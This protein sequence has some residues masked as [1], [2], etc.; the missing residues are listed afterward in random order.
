MSK[1]KNKRGICMADGGITQESPEQLMARMA[2]KY[3][4]PTGATP[5]AQPQQQS[6]QQAPQP[7][8]SNPLGIMSMLK[9]RSAQIDKAVNG[10][11]A[12]GLIQNTAEHWANDNAE[13][14]KTNPNFGQR[15]LRGLNPLTGFGSAMGAMH[16]AAGNG[17]VPGMAMAGI[18]AI[19]AFGVLRSVPAAG[20]MKAAVSPSLGRSAAALTGGAVVNAIADEYQSRSGQ[21][22]ANGGIVNGKGTPTSDDVPVKIKGKQY[23]LSDTEAV[24]PSKSR[25]ALGE[26]LG[27][28]PGNVAQA[29][30]L[31][32]KFIE[33]TNGKPPVSV[34]EGTNLADGGL[35]DE[36]ARK[37][38]YQ[39][40]TGTP[41]PAPIPAPTAAPAQPTDGISLGKSPAP[42]IYGNG[43]LPPDVVERGINTMRGQLAKPQ[44]PA[45]AAMG[46]AAVQA[47][48]VDDGAGGV[49]TPGGGAIPPDKAGSG[50]LNGI[51]GFFEDSARAARGEK[52]YEQLRA[53]RSAG[54]VTPPTA[55]PAASMNDGRVAVKADPFGP[56]PEQFSTPA[57]SDGTFM[58]GKAKYDETGL[59]QTG[60]STPD[61]SGGGFVQKNVSYN[62]NPT[63]QEG[64]TKITSSKTNPLFTNI[65]PE[66]AVASLKNQ[67]VGAHVACQEGEP[68]QLTVQLLAVASQHFS[69]PA[70]ISSIDGLRVDWPDGFG[71]IRA[72]NTTPVLVLRFEGHTQ[73]AL[74]RIEH[75]MLALLRT[76]KPDAKLQHS[77]H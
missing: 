57:N 12:G 24:L 18:S 44:S 3:G 14:E 50:I 77:V 60:M 22:Y 21:G 68:H 67:T 73:V 70:E 48:T 62:V 23:N 39:A 53:D 49:Y 74:D 19:P 64:I 66:D 61:S 7:P 34:E 4:A 69:A 76:V 43:G 52:S 32:E 54:Q 75:A 72:S 11:A 29:N 41:T 58:T 35:L 40:V 15:V 9:G 51:V 37:M 71:L 13:F 55:A 33:Q 30:A 8:K 56:K 65:R 31:V 16:T 2:A 1:G 26:M 25:Q 47:Q 46:P 10:Y 42:T 28:E 38:N 17:D 36:E 27:A 45:P 59:N 6:T 20:A 63:S 5:Q